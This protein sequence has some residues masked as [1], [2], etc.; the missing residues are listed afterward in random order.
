[1]L[2]GTNPTGSFAPVGGRQS[3]IVGSGSDGLTYWNLFN[4]EGESGIGADFRTYATLTDMLNG[5]NP[6]GFFAPVGGRQSDIVGTGSDGTTYWNLFNVEGESGIGADFRTY[7]TLT[8]MLNNINPT[9]FFAPVGGRQSDIV[10]TGSDGT[11]YWNLFNVEGESGIGADFRTYASLTDML[12]NVNPIGSFAPLGGGQS[13]IVGSGADLHPTEVPVHVPAPALS[14]VG[15][16][17]GLLVLLGVAGLALRPR[18]ARV[19]SPA[20]RGSGRGGSR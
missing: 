20:G 8:D 9:G 18:R 14:P 2:N 16:L 4:V 1:M 19:P 17:A 5:T 3:D 10:G 15:L 11:T 6:T 7:A 12:N 13:R